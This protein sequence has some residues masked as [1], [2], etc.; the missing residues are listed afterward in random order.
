MSRGRERFVC[1]H[2]LEG[3]RLKTERLHVSL[4]HAGDYKRLRT[5]FT[6]AARQ[7][8]K[9]V[10][11]HPFEMTFRFIKSFE[12]APS[13][14]GRPRRRPLVLL[15]EGDALLEL[16]KVLGAAMEKN[17]LRAAEH[18]TPHMTLFYGA[19]PIPMQ[20]IKPIRFVVNEFTLIHSELWLTQYNVVDRWSLES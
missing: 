2:H 10:S 11:M 20:A 1:E 19:K 12:G 13:T 9:A 8:G 7:A 4:H 15:G 5:K 14:N 3:A 17:G 6:Y 16:H 18:F